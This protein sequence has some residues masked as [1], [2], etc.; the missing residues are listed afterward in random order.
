MSATQERKVSTSTSHG[1]L[2]GRRAVGQRYGGKSSRTV[3]RWKKRRVIPPPDLMI[4]NREYWYED[5]LERHD[6]QLVAERAAT[7]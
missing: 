6:R 2:L 1:R 5:T 3:E 7:K 4:L